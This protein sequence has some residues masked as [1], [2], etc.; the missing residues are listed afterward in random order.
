[1]PGER[2]GAV[3]IRSVYAVVCRESDHVPS[4]CEHHVEG[5][6]RA[7]QQAR[8]SLNIKSSNHIYCEDHN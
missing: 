1:M 2:R 7:T 5:D 6:G 8:E 4:T 3:E